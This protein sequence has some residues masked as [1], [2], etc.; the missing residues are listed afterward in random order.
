M[1]IKYTLNEDDIPLSGP[2][3]LL[4]AVFG[5]RGGMKRFAVAEDERLRAGFTRIL[6]GEGFKTYFWYD[7]VWYIID[8]RMDVTAVTRSEKRTERFVLAARDAIYIRTG[9]HISPR[10]VSEKVLFLYVAV[11]A[12]IR[13]ARWLAHMT[14]EDLGDVRVRQEF[15]SRDAWTSGRA[16]RVGPKK[17]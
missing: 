15:K 16:G 2:E 12:S 8:G 4:P 13:D 1:P 10:V 5:R 3:Q 7:E 17:R 14:P 9:T 6:R 11:P